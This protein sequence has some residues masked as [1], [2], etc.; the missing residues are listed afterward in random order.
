MLVY[1]YIYIYIYNSK[2]ESDTELDNSQQTDG[3]FS[4]TKF[5]QKNVIKSSV[6]TIVSMKYV[7]TDISTNVFLKCFYTDLFT[8]CISTNI[9]ISVPTGIIVLHTSLQSFFLQHLHKGV[10]MA[11]SL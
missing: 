1:I 6:S 9:S 3:M 10:T 8:D 4:D 5:P 11:V 7:S 2:H